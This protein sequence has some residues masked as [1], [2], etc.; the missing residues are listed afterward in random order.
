VA[1]LCLDAGASRVIVCDNTLREPDLCKQKS[2]IGDALKDLKGVVIFTPKQDNLFEEK[3]HPKATVLRKTCVVKEVLRADCLISL[4]IA[5]SHSAGGV[6][7]GIKGLMGLVK[8]RDVMHREMDLHMAIAEQLY[9]MMPAVT[10]V[11]ASR[12]LLDNGPGGPGKVI[13]LD[14]FIGGID[15]VAV[16]SYATTIASW[17]GRQFEGTNVKYIKNAAQ[18]GFGNATSDKI[19]VVSV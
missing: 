14:T 11:D 1:K 12:A 19:T 17:Y 18:L 4:P 10:I 5:K 15:P 3:T 13:Q 2:G 16:D 6:S 8:D 7:F 9:Y